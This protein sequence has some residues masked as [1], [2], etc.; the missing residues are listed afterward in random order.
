MAKK[1]GCKT[2]NGIRMN[3]YQAAVAFNFANQI[4]GRAK[5]TLA[6]MEKVKS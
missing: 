1:H 5:K 2:I 6:I 4:N 3:L